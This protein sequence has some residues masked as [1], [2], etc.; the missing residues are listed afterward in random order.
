MKKGFLFVVSGPSGAG[1]STL[2]KEILEKCKDTVFSISTTSRKKRE[3]EKDGVDYFFVSK[4]EFEKEIKKESFLEWA[5]VHGN[6]YGTSARSVVK[7]LKE[8]KI[9]LFDIDVQGF[10]NI[11]KRF[12]TITTSVFVTTPSM[13]ELKRR[14]L[15][16][17][18]ENEETVKK[19]LKNAKK[20]L[21]EVKEYDY[22][23]IN[24]D[25]QKAKKEIL[26]LLGCA[27][28]KANKKDVKDFIAQ[29]E[30]I[31]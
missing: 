30:K 18:S 6:Y 12:K 27:K 2:I 28:L 31:E 20:E 23:L 8:G 14:L 4:D 9:V 22:L 7:A 26:L 29:W 1:K 17:G 3:N 13:G 24:D 16:R 19:R 15:K 21:K 5:V 25:L 10:K 11:K